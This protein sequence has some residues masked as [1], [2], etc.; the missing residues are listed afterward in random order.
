MILSEEYIKIPGKQYKVKVQCVSTRRLTTMEWL[1]VNCA[2]KFHNS[3]RTSQKSLK[4]V[5]EEIFQLTSSEILI[6]PCIESLMHDQVIVLDAGPNFDYSSLLFS[7]IRL[8]KKGRRMVQD[9]LF[10][11][12]MKELPLDIYY[13]PLT[14][15]MNQFVGGNEKKDSAIDFGTESDYSTEFPE[16]KII[17]AL[18]K[19]LVGR[20]KFVASRLRIEAIEC[21]TSAGWDTTIKL[22]IASDSEC[23]L[24]TKPE[25][26]EENVK[27]R[28][29]S[30]FFTK[31][32]TPDKMSQLV[33]IHEAQS[34]KVFGSGKKLKE[35]LLSVCR[36]GNILGIHNDIYQLYKRTTT[37]F[38]QKTIFLWR[39]KEFAIRK[40]NDSVFIEIPFD[41]S[42]NGCVA[43]NE[44]NESISF[45]KNTYT[46]DGRKIIAPIAF[47]DLRIH[48]GEKTIAQWLDQ[49]IKN[50]YNENIVYIALYMTNIFQDGEKQASELLKKY[51]SDSTIDD[52]IR[53][54]KLLSTKCIELGS[55]MPCLDDY[56]KGFWKKC[57]DLETDVI[58]ERMGEIMRYNCISAGSETQKYIMNQ[59]LERVSA[60][61]SYND[62]IPILI[63]IG[64]RNHRDA[65]LY[66]EIIE[67]LYTRELICDTLHVIMQNKFSKI[68]EMFE[69]DVLF[70]TYVQAI[71]ELEFLISG[72]KMFEKNNLEEIESAVENCADIALIQSYASEILAK[73]GELL[74]R[75]INVY[76]EMKNLDADKADVYFENLDVIKQKVQMMMN[77]E[78]QSMKSR[79]QKMNTTATSVVAQRM[80][81]V[82]TCALMHHPDILLSFKT[83]DFVRIPTKVID[84]LGKI[85]D[86]RSSKYSPD[87]SRQAARII[88]DIEQKYLKLFNVENKMRLM[89]ENADLDILPADLDKRVPDNQIL[90]VALK[91]KE[92]D[93]VIISDDGALRLTASAQNLKTMTSEEFLIDHEIYKRSLNRWIE[94]FEKAGGVFHKETAIAV[95]TSVGDVQGQGVS[96]VAADSRDTSGK[97]NFA[98]ASADSL[99]VRELK[100]ILGQDLTEPACSLLQNN[101][102][103]T[104]GQFKQLTQQMAQ[105]L[106]AKGKQTVL[107]NNIVRAVNKFQGYLKSTQGSDVLESGSVH[108]SKTEETVVEDHLDFITENPLVG[109]LM[110][111]IKDNKSETALSL[112][113]GLAT[114]YNKREQT[115]MFRDIIKKSEVS[116]Y[117]NLLY[118]ILTVFPEWQI[119]QIIKYLGEPTAQIIEDTVDF[120]NIAKALVNDEKYELLNLLMKIWNIEIDFDKYFPEIGKAA[121]LLKINST[122]SVKRYINECLEND[123]TQVLKFFKENYQLPAKV[124]SEFCI[125]MITGNSLLANEFEKVL[126]DFFKSSV[127]KN[128]TVLHTKDIV[129]IAIAL[130]EEEEDVLKTIIEDCTTS[131]YKLEVSKRYAQINPTPKTLEPLHKLIAAH[132]SCSRI[133]YIYMNTGMKSAINLD[134]FISEMSLNG[135]SVDQVLYFL[136]DYWL[137][138]TIKYVTDDGLVR[139]ASTS[140]SNSRLMVFHSDN[141]HINGENGWEDPREGMTIYFKLKDYKEGGMFNIHYPCTDIIYSK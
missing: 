31:E 14:E 80:Y 58:L 76:S 46:Y 70:N 114:A 137:V 33:W 11:G 36:N 42:V 102:I 85:K 72:L 111:A 12:A 79:F 116:S 8:T 44:K 94:K 69:L 77:R 130:P 131:Y 43:I 16:E 135:Y 105:G 56:G 75:G 141:I 15:T 123:E 1:I 39:A 23:N 93:T 109:Q 13:N 133:V 3:A 7:Q 48:V 129:D 34:A 21:M 19:G 95:T 106:K 73:H 18:H 54:I 30:L 113:S 103:R 71:K 98:D 119:R 27:H 128:N 121:I 136:R 61:K 6:K 17:E 92:W 29:T 47:E 90:S 64:I 140:A 117:T 99:P 96:T 51:W 97:Q 68:P 81:I 87:L 110:E 22:E 124:I 60:P 53:D 91:Y 25:I 41:F 10:P 67:K 5:F 52:V 112:F 45:G 120:E 38:K 134:F 40:E 32:I 20:G 132:I 138:G 139:V 57:E 50:A 37:A 66:D 108:I 89:I 83:E 78:T 82:D 74:N 84:E 86:M 88:S 26:M 101:G 107:R 49:E 55:T 63:S 24:T 62:L 122:E 100:K 104:I 28:I 35:Y 115:L 127:D 59:I 4:Y 2:E 9:G 125:K 65:L 118:F 126:C